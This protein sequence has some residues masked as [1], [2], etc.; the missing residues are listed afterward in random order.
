MQQCIPEVFWG[1]FSLSGM[2][3]MT[4]QRDEGGQRN[5]RQ[6]ESVN[7]PDPAGRLRTAIFSRV[8]LWCGQRPGRLIYRLNLKDLIAGG[9]AKFF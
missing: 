4:W 6:L 5:I 2:L 3:S 1:S 8:P 9:G 7:W